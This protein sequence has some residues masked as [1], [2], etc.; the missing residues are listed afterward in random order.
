MTARRHGFGAAERALFLALALL[1]ACSAFRGGTAAPHI[2]GILPDSVAVVAGAV[3]EVVIRG[4]GFAPGSPGRNTVQFGELSLADVPASRDGRTIP[5]VVPD[6]M[7]LRGDAAPLPLEAG[8][9]EIRVRTALG[10]SNA[11]VVRVSR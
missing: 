6:R 9:Y 8:P 4:R 2:D 10:V 7:P 3:V 1:V 5:F 11:V